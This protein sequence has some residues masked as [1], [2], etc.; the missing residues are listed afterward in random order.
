[1]IT[2]HQ[3]SIVPPIARNAKLSKSHVSRVNNEVTIFDENF[4]QVAY[5]GTDGSTISN[6]SK[7]TAVNQETSDD[8]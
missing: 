1:M 4:P 7:H 6:V 3:K 5:R 2:N 8:E